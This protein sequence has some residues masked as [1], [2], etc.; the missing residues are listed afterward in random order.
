MM[1]GHASFEFI[2]RMADAAQLQGLF[3]GGAMGAIS[4]FMEF[5]Q[6][7]LVA[8]VVQYGERATSWMAL[9]FLAVLL[10]LATESAFALQAR[11]NARSRARAQARADKAGGQSARKDSER[12]EKENR[13]AFLSML[14]LE[15][16]SLPGLSIFT[17]ITDLLERF[18][19]R[20]E[21]KRRRKKNATAEGAHPAEPSTQDEPASEARY[22]APSLGP[23]Y[24]LSAYTTFVLFILF[25]SAKP[26]IAFAYDLS[27][28]Q[29][30]WT[31]LFFGD[32]PYGA[33]LISMSGLR[34]LEIIISGFAWFS[35]FWITSI[36]TRLTR[37]SKLLDHPPTAEQ[38]ELVHSRKYFA[39]KRLIAPDETFARWARIT[40]FV[41][42]GSTI[43]GIPLIL[44]ERFAVSASAFA[45]GLVVLNG[46]WFHLFLKGDAGG[47][48]EEE[49]AL[50]DSAEEAQRPGFSAV[51]DLLHLHHGASPPELPQE[52]RAVYP[53]LNAGE[54]RPGA[55][56]RAAPEA[57]EGISALLAEFAAAGAGE[58]LILS[59]DVLATL[60]RVHDSC[61][62][63]ARTPMEGEDGELGGLYL[64]APAESGKT[65]LGVLAAVNH[66]LKH[67][68]MAIVVAHSSKEAAKL[69]DRINKKLNACT[70]RWTLNVRLA[71]RDLIQDEL[72]G[73]VPEI[74]V[75]DLNWIAGHLLHDQNKYR[76][77]LGAIGL[78][79]VDDIESYHG[80]MA[81]Q[82][83]L[84]FARLNLA[85]SRTIAARDA[86]REVGFLALSGDLEPSVRA[87]AGKLTKRRLEELK[88]DADIP[89]FGPIDRTREGSALVYNLEDFVDR[90]GDPLTLETIVRACE[91]AKV[92]WA[93]CRAGVDRRTQS[94]DIRA[95]NIPVDAV[96]QRVERYSEAGVIFVVGRYTH[97]GG[98]LRRLAAAGHR[99]LEKPIAGQRTVAIIRV[100]D[101]D[102]R[103]ALE[104][105]N[106]K[107]SL[108]ELMRRL[109]LR[110]A[111]T[112]P[113]QVIEAHL[114]AE[115]RARSLEAKE[116]LD[117]FGRDALLQSFRLAKAERIRVEIAQEIS[118]DGRNFEELAEL[119]ATAQAF[120]KTSEDE[121][122]LTYQGEE[123]RLLP[124]PFRSLE[125][126]RS[127]SLPIVEHPSE[128]RLFEMNP[129]VARFLCYPGA[130]LETREGP[131]VVIEEK[132][133]KSGG[134]APRLKIYV[135]PIDE[136]LISVPERS[137]S[138]QLVDHSNAAPRRIYFG[139]ESLEIIV[140][141]ARIFG[142]H[143]ATRWLDPVTAEP[144]ARHIY[145]DAHYAPHSL[146]LGNKSDEGPELSV[147]ILNIAG[148]GDGAEARL[149]RHARA[150]LLATIRQC[151]GLVYHDLARVSDV[152]L[153]RPRGSHE[154]PS[155]LVFFD[156]IPEGS[157]AVAN[158]ERDGLPLLLRLSRL[159]VE[160]VLRPRRIVARFN[161]LPR[162]DD[163]PVSGAS[164]EPPLTDE[165]EIATR[166]LVL[167]F[168]NARLYAETAMRRPTRD[169][170]YPTHFELNPLGSESIGRAFITAS[171]GVTDLRWTRLAHRS[172]LRRVV[173][174]IDVG[175]SQELIRELERAQLR[176]NA[177]LEHALTQIDEHAEVRGAG[178]QD[179][180]MESSHEPMSRAKQGLSVL[181]RFMAMLGRIFKLGKKH[182]AQGIEALAENAA[183]E[184]T[185]LALN[186][187]AEDEQE[188]PHIVPA[189][190]HG[191]T[192]IPEGGQ[193]DSRAAELEGTLRA[194][195]E[196][197]DAS[198]GECIQENFLFIEPLTTLL[199]KYLEQIT[200]S[201]EG[202]FSDSSLANNDRV[203]DELLEEALF[204]EAAR[205]F[206]ELISTRRG[207]E[208]AQ[209]AFA[210]APEE[211]ALPTP[212][213]RLSLN[214]PG[215]MLRHGV[216][217]ELSAALALSTLQR[218]LGRSTGCFMNIATGQVLGAIHIDGP[219]VALEGDG[220]AAAI[221][222]FRERHLTESGAVTPQ[223]KRRLRER[224]A[225]YARDAHGLHLAVDL[226]HTRQ[227]SVLTHEYRGEWYFM[228]FREG[229]GGS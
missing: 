123:I 138:Y 124:P 161:D 47:E 120:M 128:E 104:M 174:S 88:R 33:A 60:L 106:A 199:Q 164:P 31:S 132:R 111:Q 173:R 21:K 227:L 44:S 127:A 40:F 8:W 200:N 89:L 212:F 95:L 202:A 157:D 53:R 12:G 66:A 92:P 207:D 217:S 188:R 7:Q 179:D 10:T 108:D 209:G 94:G 126:A 13:S 30:A 18:R 34:N 84:V 70:L 69:R 73:S 19:R 167:E 110:L 210:P 222:A 97:V 22:L 15:L 61:N 223:L 186:E 135:E 170:D 23:S 171:M 180:E 175:F 144:K 221:G 37:A 125:S 100:V 91:E 98:E 214:E 172:G 163:P 133:H 45:V 72:Q 226:K 93:Y 115:L 14:A 113:Q 154:E 9:V 35:L 183:A 87:S 143:H 165:E 36:V 158:L 59:E 90:K 51:L 78:I 145:Q 218:L 152:S 137:L 155:S 114:S 208:H 81:T 204:V 112:P 213:E 68:T 178:A 67:A 150:L 206:G 141:R 29:Y 153:M 80:A 99:F 75:C 50:P 181:R 201:R 121:P 54:L 42:V 46:W 82:A 136:G 76:A 43:I 140:T 187:H 24:F 57:S 56:N 169:R 190:L 168:L 147:L 195:Y 182:A 228:P 101:N 198:L 229:A 109:P 86:Q 1:A 71:D 219:G 191:F 116:I 38:S 79:V 17:R 118:K 5:V 96:S 166:Q 39:I 64:A 49:E 119:H 28:T 103:M 159:I 107:G 216:A 3:F 102:E 189:H 193:Q 177:A 52:A 20:R 215:L 85:L 26:I 220:E 162:L 32:K 16:A 196:A 192:D 63:D 48:S 129:H 184:E 139:A 131:R 105:G 194:Q 130:I 122:Y 83:Q 203:E 27:T 55:E 205:L 65:S 77:I 148:L 74:L 151:V 211:H 149:R 142:T 117:Y 224:P 197:L 160:R 62:P 156:L 25:E 225:I 176:R 11:F 134:S 146:S 4:A 41:L 185:A 6:Q 2:A 58:Q